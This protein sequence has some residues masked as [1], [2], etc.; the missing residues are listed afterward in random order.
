M[1]A[2]A[3]LI[4]TSIPAFFAMFLAYFSR[5]H[6]TAIAAVLA[7]V[8]TVAAFVGC[9]N[10]LLQ[11][12]ISLLVVPAWILAF[13]GMFIPGNFALILSTLISGRICKAAFEM[14]KIKIDLITKAN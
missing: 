8:A 14:S 11:T 12:L 5:K 1:F 2:L 3:K 9:I 7:F 13:F 10:F 4:F 6:T